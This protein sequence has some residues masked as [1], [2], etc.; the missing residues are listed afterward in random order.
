MTSAC[1]YDAEG[2]KCPRCKKTTAAGR[3]NFDGLCDRCQ[4]LILEH[5]PDH[6]SVPFI[7]AS[8]EAQR[9]RWGL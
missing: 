4:E 3:F 7:K 6:E 8:L 2:V 1:V 9:A 5:F